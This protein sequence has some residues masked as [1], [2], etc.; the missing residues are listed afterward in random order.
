MKKT[1]MLA[2]KLFIITAVAT[3]VLAIVNSK[4]APIVEAREKQEYEE[5]L[6][7]V[8]D[9]ADKFESLSK[10]DKD[11]FNEVASKNE[12]IE[13]IVLAYSGNEEVGYVF[14]VVGKGGYGGPITFVIGVD[15]EN[16][17]IG[18]EVLISSETKGFGSQVSEDP[19]KSSVVGT[20]MDEKIV[21][22]AE[23]SG[24][25]D[26][27]AISGTTISV[28]AILNGLNGAVSALEELGI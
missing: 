24:D 11:K 5:S 4:T 18:Y 1:V 16:T 6:A 14:K 20:K 15:K 9:G 2:V 8:F 27:Q 3:G 7:K 22:A 13:D 12:N 23:P 26:I 28:K 21:S 25:N 19:F 17:I 10:T